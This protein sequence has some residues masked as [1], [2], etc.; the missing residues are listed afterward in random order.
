[1]TLPM[2]GFFIVKNNLGN[3][4]NCGLF[5]VYLRDGGREKG[6]WKNK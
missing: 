2:V 3:A 5:F 6:E 1:M 4:W